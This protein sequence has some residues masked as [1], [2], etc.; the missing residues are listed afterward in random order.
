MVMLPDIR[1]F[2]KSA[3]FGLGGLLKYS[4]PS[5]PREERCFLPCPGFCVSLQHWHLFN[6]GYFEPGQLYH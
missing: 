6:G 3:G 1:R 5:S 2:E 4:D